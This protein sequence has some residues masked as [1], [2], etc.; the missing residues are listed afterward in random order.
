MAQ[1]G[2]GEGWLVLHLGG[3]PGADAL[4]IFHQ[5]FEFL[6]RRV[7]G[8]VSQED[9]TE[10]SPGLCLFGGSTPDCDWDE[11]FPSKEG[12]GVGKGGKYVVS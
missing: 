11:I 8:G 2:G 6:G 4:R 7:D 3:E 10:Y 5:I 1:E 12:A 9:C